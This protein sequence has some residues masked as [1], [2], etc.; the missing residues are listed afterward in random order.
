MNNKVKNIL[1]VTHQFVPHQSPR[2]T[3]WKLIYDE[4][5]KQGFNIRVITGT[6]QDGSDSNIQYIGNK[7]ASGVV[8]S[9]RKQSNTDQGSFYKNLALKF[10]KKIYRFFYKFFA[11]PDY[12][13]FWVFSI[14]KNRKKIDFDYDVIISVSLPF[15][16]H[17][18]AYIIN[19]EKRKKWIMD[20]GDP[21]SLKSNAFEN[22]KYF[23]KSL[24][25]YIEN[26]FFKMADQIVFTHKD[27]SLEHKEFFNI[28]NEKIEIGNPI[29]AFSK[30]VYQN[31]KKYNYNIEPIK[32]GYFGILTKGVRS[33][34]EVLKYFQN[35]DYVFHW[36]TNPDSKN[37]ILQNNID[38]NKHLFFDMVPRNE[39][40]E[41]MVTS[42][43]CLLSIGN[44][45]ASQLPSKVI[46]YISTG[47]PVI[48]FAEISNDPVIKIS[49]KF[50][51]LIVVTKKSD[52]LILNEQLTNVFQNIDMFD[53][54]QFNNIYSAEAVTKKLN[55]F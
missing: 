32:I 52:P 5:V 20:I 10:L 27:A 17:V 41:I 22:N 30:N 25:Y 54:E 48:H 31:S 4:L 29:S 15:S 50:K 12:T 47:K 37:M 38:Q 26:K 7:T 21:F 44:L 42:F 35:L 16:S 2:T 39:A 8:S 49:E 6:R 46:E 33:P 18:A 3:R 45:N 13:M 34:N 36:Y 55:I 53:I 19:K 11:W 43:H 51:N 28:N 23:Y 14:W 1:I 24:N 9:L 40:L